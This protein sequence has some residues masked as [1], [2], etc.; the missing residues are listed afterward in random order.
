MRR[1]PTAILTVLL[2]TI[3]GF[4]AN[5]MGIDPRF[6]PPTTPNAAALPTVHERVEVQSP[7]KFAITRVDGSRDQGPWSGFDLEAMHG[8]ESPVRWEDIEPADRLRVGREI[9]RADAEESASEWSLLIA[10]L[11]LSVA[12][13][14][15]ERGRERLRRVAGSEFDVWDAATRRLV[16]QARERR[17][18]A[19]EVEAAYSMRRTRPH[20]VSPAATGSA[21]PARRA[22]RTAGEIDEDRA[23]LRRLVDAEVEGLQLEI[24]PTA[25]TLAIAAGSL[26]DVA[27]LGVRADR[28]LAA[29]R[30]RLGG[31]PEPSL[32]A[33][34]LAIIDPGDSDVARVLLARHLVD[35]P[36]DEP[37]ML[38]PRPEGWIAILAAPDT[39]RRTRWAQALP[40]GE[41]TIVLRDVELARI[42]ARVA[43]LEAGAGRVPSWM[44]EGFAEAA[45]QAMLPEAPLEELGRPVA[46][47]TIRDGRHPAWVTQLDPSDPGWGVDGLARRTSHLLMSRLL[48]SGD[49]VVP[50]IVR[51]LASGEDID[52]AFQ[53]TTGRSSA[54]WLSDSADWFCTND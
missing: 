5:G 14:M 54:S 52:Q 39:S 33:G 23:R 44:V 49:A 31:P 35:W 10:A 51:A 32:P 28:F 7:R 47:A 11:D 21:I 29:T 43:M 27:A 42:A 25:M 15:A 45:A 13:D 46:V 30:A 6:G 50:A 9:L 26:E 22:G 2:A 24:V 38:V 37:S 40:D 18:L 1:T 53:R 12:A 19:R 4:S 48:E 36:A 20:L 34:G 16:E 3:G 8:P 41:A 17:R